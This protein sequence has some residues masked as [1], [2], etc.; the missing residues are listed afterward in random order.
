MKIVSDNYFF[1]E[2]GFQIKDSN[3]FQV[4]T[5]SYDTNNRLVFVKNCIL[6]AKECYTTKYFYEKNLLVKEFLK[7]ALPISDTIYGYECETIVYKYDKNSNLVE[8]IKNSDDCYGSNINLIEHKK[9]YYNKE[10]NLILVE[11]LSKKQTIIENI[12]YKYTN[13]KIT[14]KC[15]CKESEDENIF[16]CIKNIYTYNK[17]YEIKSL[18]TIYYSSENINKIFDKE[19]TMYFYKYDKYKRIIEKT[20]LSSFKIVIQYKKF[21]DKGNWIE[22]IEFKND[23]IEQYT[24]REIEYY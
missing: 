11:Y 4:I 9:L 16:D 15:S 6:D 14:E 18:E 1:N 21:D 7:L 3:S 23:Q 5:Y 13:N 19:T 10:N 17:N 12:I 20:E 2:K 22:K 8:I 24:K